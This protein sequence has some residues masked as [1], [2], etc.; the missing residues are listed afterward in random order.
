MGQQQWQEKGNKEDEEED[1]RWV[2]NGPGDE[3]PPR[4]EVHVKPVTQESSISDRDS[5]SSSV[6][7]D[8]GERGEAVQ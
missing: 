3:D 8:R 1:L 2:N 6:A 5:I 7:A 4:I